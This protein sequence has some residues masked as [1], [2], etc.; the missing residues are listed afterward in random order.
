MSISIV[1]VFH[2][3]IKYTTRFFECSAVGEVDS[4]SFFVASMEGEVWNY[5]KI[6]TALGECGRQSIVVSRHEWKMHDAFYCAFDLQGL[7]FRST[8]N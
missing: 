3:F 1:K 7:L 5:K 2:E 4:E 6:T 8:L